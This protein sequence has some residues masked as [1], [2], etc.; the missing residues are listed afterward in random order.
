MHRKRERWE[1]VAVTHPCCLPGGYAHG[2][3]E[4][5]VYRPLVNTE[6]KLR[7]PQAALRCILPL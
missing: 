2:E 3:T 7:A 5:V 6:T 4:A 1:L